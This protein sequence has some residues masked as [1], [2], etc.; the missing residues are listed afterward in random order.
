MDIRVELE[1]DELGAAYLSRKREQV[2][3]R[4]GRSAAATTAKSRF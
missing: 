1:E 2:R 3:A 4:V